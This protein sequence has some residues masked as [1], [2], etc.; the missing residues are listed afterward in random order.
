MYH[1]AIKHGRDNKMKLRI[2]IDPE[3]PEEIIIRGPEYNEKINR[4]KSVLDGLTDNS[5]DIALYSGEREF[6]IPISKLLFFE[7]Y[8]N[9]VWAHTQSNIYQCQ[10]NLSQLEE[11]LPRYFVRSSKSCVINIKEISSIKRTASGIGEAG[12]YKSEKIAYISRMYYH[13]I[14]DRIE[15]MRL[16]Q[17]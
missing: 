10:M 6:F 2:E 15:E 7:T 4:I 14:R 3:L 8:D 1:I 12:F 11:I 16:K 13:S 9:K 17:K 5:S